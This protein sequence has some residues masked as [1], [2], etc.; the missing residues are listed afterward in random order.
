MKT[1]IKFLGWIGRGYL[2]L[3]EAISGW[4]KAHKESTPQQN[5]DP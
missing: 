3:V 5:I 4:T 1:T 2:A